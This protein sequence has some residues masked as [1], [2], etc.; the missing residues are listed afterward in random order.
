VSMQTADQ[1]CVKKE[2]IAKCMPLSTEVVFLLLNKYIWKNSPY[3]LPA[4]NF[5]VQWSHKKTSFIERPKV[6]KIT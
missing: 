4:V 5:I 1:T 3:I 2:S 6:F